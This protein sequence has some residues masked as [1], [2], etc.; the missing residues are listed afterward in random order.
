MYLYKN[1]KE[2]RENKSLAA[3]LISEWARPIFNIQTDF[4]SLTKEERVQ[5]DL[6]HMPQTKKKR[7][8]R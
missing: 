2:T 8:N 4:R 1:P 5:R 7:T 3:K 6:E